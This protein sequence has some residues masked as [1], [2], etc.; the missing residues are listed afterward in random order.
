[1][2]Q[3]KKSNWLP[4]D[5]TKNCVSCNK[6]FTLTRR[7]HHCRACGRLFCADCSNKKVQL[8]HMGLKGTQRVCSYCHKIEQKRLYW[9]QT[10]VPLLQ[11][12]SMMLVHNRFS[13]DSRFVKLSDDEKTIQMMDDKGK[14]LKDSCNLASLDRV[15]SGKTTSNLKKAKTVPS[16]SC[17]AIIGSKTFEFEAQDKKAKDVWVKALEAITFVNKQIDPKELAQ[18]AQD[19]YMNKQYDTQKSKQF[20]KNQKK[21]DDIRKKYKI[22]R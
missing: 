5:A 17:F 18:K 19:E 15:V 10:G 6:A 21:R 8:P 9:N 13:T 22:D 4:D 11:R 16:T 20:E 7:K 3:Q 2:A 14:K 12:G 1:M